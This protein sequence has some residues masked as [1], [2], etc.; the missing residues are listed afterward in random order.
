[1]NA[2]FADADEFGI[3][4]RYQDAT[5]K[6]RKTSAKTRMILLKAMGADYFL[7][8]KISPVKILKPGENFLVE[9]PSELT[10]EDGTKLRVENFLPRDLPWGYHDLRPLSSSETTRLIVSPGVCYLPEDLRAWGFAIQLY[11]LRS[12]KS[13][14][15]GDFSDLRQCANWSAKKLRCDFLLLNPL[16]AANPILPQ[17]TSPYFPG[18]R[19]FLNPLY[20]RIEEIPGA[21]ELKL[22]LEKFAQ[23][24]RELNRERLIDRDQI[25]E[26]KMAALKKI[27]QKFP[28]DAAF[29]KFCAEQGAALKNFASFCALAEF[30]GGGWQKWPQ[31]FRDPNSM[32][33]KSFCAEYF[34]IVQFFQWL[35]W[36]LENQLARAAKE[37]FLMHDLP[38]GFDPG[39]AD[40]WIWQ[41]LLAKNVSVGAPPDGF[42]P[43]GQDWGL[44]PFVLHRL[45]AAGYEPFR[46][47]LRAILR[48]GKGLRID[49]VMGL[50]RL[51]W[52]PKNFSAR[53]GAYVRYRADELLAIVALESQRAKAVIVGEDLGTIE[54]GVREELRR[55]KIL[56]YRLL[57][58][59]NKSPKKF[60]R[61]AMAAVTTHDLFTVAGLWTGQDLAEQ[62]KL[63]LRP[64]ETG[65]N[66]ILKKLQRRIGLPARA[67]TT[68]AVARTYENLARAPSMLLTATLDDALAV[69]SR[70]N[71]PGLVNRRNWSLALPKSLSAIQKNLLVKKLATVLRR[72]K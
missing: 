50:F 26:L 57:W 55:R 30:H 52:I 21:R 47:M 28:G 22:P 20:L 15:M 27:W 17:Q 62:K 11:A 45:R 29:E 69:E 10:L 37:I 8:P 35:Q 63:G 1:M 48:H 65:V 56:S 38:I 36:H 70:P 33:V 40:A 7:T 16:G 68:E 39:G 18:S 31:K 12:Q 9:Q 6:W 67:P 23:A 54:P 19:Q 71:V 46:Q 60:P 53:D 58:F 66:F 51:F 64:D 13:W 61:R 43:H 4:R 25:F 34:K 5:G 42:N 3:M 41:N 44:P 32:A 24:G 72:E 2:T 49:H 59:E 14:G